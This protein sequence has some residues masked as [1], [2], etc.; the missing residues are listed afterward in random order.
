MSTTNAMEKMNVVLTRLTMLTGMKRGIL[1]TKNQRWMTST[2]VSQKSRVQRK[3][4][5]LTSPIMSR[6]VMKMESL[7]ASITHPFTKEDQ[8]PAMQTGCTNRSIGLN[9]LTA[10]V[11]RRDPLPLML[12]LR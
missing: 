10:S 11:L 1:D 9:S 2:H 8:D 3:L 12:Q 4:L 7:T 5:E 6:I